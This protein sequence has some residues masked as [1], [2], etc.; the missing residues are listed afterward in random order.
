VV[1]QPGQALAGLEVLFCCPPDSGDLDQGEQ[2][3]G[4]WAV[5][6]VERQFGGAPAAADQQPAVAGLAG[7]NGHPGPVVVAVAF[8]ALAGRVPLPRPAGQPGGDLAGRA[9]ARDAGDPMGDTLVSDSRCRGVR[10]AHEHLTG[11][12]APGPVAAGVAAYNAMVPAGITART[13]AQVTALFGGLPLVAPGVVPATEWRPDHHTRPSQGADMYAGLAV[14]GR[15]PRSKS[16]QLTMSTR[17]SG[18]NPAAHLTEP[19]AWRA[20]R[21]VRSW[22]KCEPP[23][24][25]STQELR[26][27]GRHDDR[28]PFPRAA[29]RQQIHVVLV[30]VPREPATTCHGRGYGTG[31]RPACEDR[32]GFAPPS[33]ARAS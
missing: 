29:P 6:A 31:I 11:D 7:V 23:A 19:R 20:R 14:T 27:P 24:T 2:R 21:H 15:R 9:G 28:G 30:R 22:P 18:G 26:A 32:A 16:S 13:H 8:G 25:R 4:T 17:A 10:P 12:F 1:I 5:A 33:P 3:D